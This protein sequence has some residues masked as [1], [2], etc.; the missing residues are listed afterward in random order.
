[1]LKKFIESQTRRASI[2]NAFTVL[3]CEPNEEIL[4]KPEFYSN[5]KQALKPT[6]SACIKYVTAMQN[7]AEQ[8]DSQKLLVDYT[9]LFLGPF[10]MMAPPYSAMYMGDSKSLMNEATLWVINFMQNL[11]IEFNTGLKDA[12]DHIAVETE[13]LYFLTYQQ[14]EN[15][16]KENTDEA[17]QL[18][19]KYNEFISRHFTKWVPQLCDKI[20]KNAA[21]PFYENLGLCLKEYLQNYNKPMMPVTENN[22]AAK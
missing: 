14:L 7:E 8:A 20:I 16:N 22:D 4:K 17:R 18:L 19:E 13:L 12:P 9:R 21:E 2:Y 6:N 15:I 3:F 1:M 11:G 5:F 10:K